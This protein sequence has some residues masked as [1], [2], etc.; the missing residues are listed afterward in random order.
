MMAAAFLLGALL[1]YGRVAEVS[2]GLG[3]PPLL[4]SPWTAPR[5]DSDGL[6]V[7]W[8]PML[9]F[10]LVVLGLVAGLGGKTR[11]RLQCRG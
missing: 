3:L 8:I 4:L 5:G 10:F 7:L 2:V 1:G 9:F 11:E 6:W